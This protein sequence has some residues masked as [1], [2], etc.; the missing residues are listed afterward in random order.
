M[1]N[2]QHQRAT[3]RRVHQEEIDQYLATKEQLLQQAKASYDAAKEAYDKAAHHDE[4][5]H[6]RGANN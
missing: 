4:E 6:R 2:T 5:L 1:T 3:Q